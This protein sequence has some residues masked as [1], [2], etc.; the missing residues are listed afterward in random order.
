MLGPDRTSFRRKEKAIEF[1]KPNCF[2]VG[3]PAHLF[4]PQSPNGA[5][6]EAGCSRG[7]DGS[8]GGNEGRKEKVIRERRKG[9]TKK[10]SG[11]ISC[12][13]LH[14]TENSCFP[15]F[16]QMKGACPS[17]L[18]RMGWGLQFISVHL[19]NSR[20]NS[21]PMSCPMERLSWSNNFGTCG[22]LSCQQFR[23]CIKKLRTPQNESVSAQSGPTLCDPE[24]CNPP[25]SSVHGILQA[26]IL[27]SVAISFS[28]RSS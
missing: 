27:E 26:R 2:Q 15:H 16:L 5:H 17:L 4:S 3:W 11:V 10:A 28:G 25:G 19:Q 21:S 7:E 14:A 18:A 22:V 9:K 24:D 20:M 1:R 13:L 23:V 6:L 12:N 8:V